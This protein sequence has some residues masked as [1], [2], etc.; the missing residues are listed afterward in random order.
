VRLDEAR[1]P[2]QGAG[3][4]LSIA[5]AI[6]EAHGGSLV[7]SRSDASGS[8]FVARLPRNQEPQ[9]ADAPPES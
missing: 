9:P 4:G 5:R 8:T 2:S 7:L 6:A 1:G 3:L